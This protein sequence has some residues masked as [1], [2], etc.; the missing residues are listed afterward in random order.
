MST[1]RP[2][3]SSVL[4]FDAV[5]KSYGSRNAVDGLGFEVAERSVTGLLGAN[6]A[7]K[8]TTMKLLLGL[9]APNSGQIELFGARQGTAAFAGAVRRTGSQIELPAL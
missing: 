8:S 1:L 3:A 7:G 4:S 5:T 9:A 2:V 6:G